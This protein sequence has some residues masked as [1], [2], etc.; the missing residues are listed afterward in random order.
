M[1]AHRKLTELYDQWRQLTEA[2]GEAIR[3][4]AWSRVEQCQRSKLDLQ[5]RI[6]AVTEEWEA[7]LLV[8]QAPRA[9]QEQALRKV[10][11]EMIRL[12]SR[13]NQWL[14]EQRQ[15]ARAEEAEA[16]RALSHLRQVHKAYGPPAPPVWQSYS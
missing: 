6:L 4:A 11:D 2:E 7:E 10:V 5:H 9:E 13:N 8:T 16:D 14:A 12:E 15:T 1:H 3:T